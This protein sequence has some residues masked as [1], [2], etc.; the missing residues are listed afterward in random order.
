M[1]R[2]ELAD[3]WFDSHSESVRLYS[4]GHCERTGRPYRRVFRDTLSHAWLSRLTLPETRTSFVQLC[5]SMILYC[6]PL[7]TYASKILAGH[8]L[9]PVHTGD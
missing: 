8:V 2:G 9:S 3:V 4:D 7:T 6:L 5:R 1:Y